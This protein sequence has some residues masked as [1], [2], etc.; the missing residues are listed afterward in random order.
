[1]EYCYDKQAKGIESIALLDNSSKA[2]S[3]S[4]ALIRT[5]GVF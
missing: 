2:A 5:S 3:Y 1:M 4:P